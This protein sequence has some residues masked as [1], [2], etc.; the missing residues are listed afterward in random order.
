MLPSESH[1]FKSLDRKII[2]GMSKAPIQ[3]KQVMLGSLIWFP[4][5][6]C[7]W[8]CLHF[9]WHFCVTQM[10][11]K[12]LWMTETLSFI[13]EWT[14]GFASRITCTLHA[15]F[16]DK[17]NYMEWD[18]YRSRAHQIVFN[19]STIYS[20]SRVSFWLKYKIFY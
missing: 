18:T 8:H 1:N 19:T 12:Y 17:F 14:T 4:T 16:H 10:C 2:T 7:K 15:C 6:L 11:T 9:R 5:L 13:V 20:T 3:Y